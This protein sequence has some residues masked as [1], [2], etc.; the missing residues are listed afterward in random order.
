M[1]P[2]SQAGTDLV[3]RLV[4]GHERDGLCAYDRK[5]KQVLVH[6]C[7][8]SGASMAPIALNYGVSTNLLR[9]VVSDR[10]RHQSAETRVRRAFR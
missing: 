9:S 6:A 1:S 10:F 8:Q 3:A 4:I 7:Q 2:E 5:A